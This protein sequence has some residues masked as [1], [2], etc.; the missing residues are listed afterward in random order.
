MVNMCDLGSGYDFKVAW[1]TAEIG[2]MDPAIAA[3]VVY[4]K[5]PEK[6]REKM[7]VKMI[8][9]TSPYP[10]AGLYHLHDVIHPKNTRKY[11][12]EVLK[13]IRDSSG[14]G[15]SKHFLATWPKKF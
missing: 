11:I 3:D 4:G 12:I 9:D 14:Q 1:P 10:A 7:L 6:E 15:M 5:L 2:F 13:I 8:A